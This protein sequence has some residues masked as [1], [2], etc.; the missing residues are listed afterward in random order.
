MTWQVPVGNVEHALLVATW[1][2]LAQLL[3]AAGLLAVLVL[4]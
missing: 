1:T 3:L 4:S 2:Q